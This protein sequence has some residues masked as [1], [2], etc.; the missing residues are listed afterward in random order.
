MTKSRPKNQSVDIDA[1]FLEGHLIDQAINT[2]VKIAVERHKKLS[3]SIVV[4]RD[5]KV[6]TIE[7]KD[8]DNEVA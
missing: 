3:Y 5:G 2:A 4:W 7:P 1:L 8:I 6:V